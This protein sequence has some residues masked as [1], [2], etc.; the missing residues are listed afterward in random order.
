MK[1]PLAQFKY[2]YLVLQQPFPGSGFKLLPMLGGTPAE[3]DML[4][5]RNAQHGSR[6]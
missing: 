3:Y 5:K 2:E 4:K 1:G 6:A